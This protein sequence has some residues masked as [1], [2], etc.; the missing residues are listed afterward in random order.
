MKA[1]ITVFLLTLN[2]EH[3]VQRCLDRFLPWAAEVLV[4]DS[5]S[6]DRTREIATAAGARVIVQPWLGWVP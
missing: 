1:P 6:T 4:V 2:E 5:G 3:Y